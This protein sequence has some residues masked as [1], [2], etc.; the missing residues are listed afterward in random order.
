MFRSSR[1]GDFAQLS[2]ATA[3]N[4]RIPI[5]A[6]GGIIWGRL[7]VL[8]K[9]SRSSLRRFHTSLIR[10]SSPARHFQLRTRVLF[11]SDSGKV[12]VGIR[13]LRLVDNARAAEQVYLCTRD[14]RLRWW[15]LR[16]WFG[17]LE[18]PFTAR[19]RI[20]PKLRATQGAT[21]L[22][23]QYSQLNRGRSPRRDPHLHCT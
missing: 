15:V 5:R 18:L 20:L 22:R 3:G 6:S 11:A 13:S 21:C 1:F 4:F 17:I 8:R 7:L 9:D 16:R 2:L 12:A 19:K 10:S 14:S 23:A